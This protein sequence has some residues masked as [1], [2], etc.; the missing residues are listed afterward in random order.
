MLSYPNI[1]PVA[2]QLGPLAVHWY[3]LMY[4]VGF[5]AAW[6]LGRWR[7]RQS[8]RGWRPQELDDVV[9]Y[10][11]IGVIVGGR[12]GYVLFYD[13][14]RF[15]E[16]PAALLQV[17]RGGMSFHGGLLGVLVAL[18]LYGRR[19]GRGFFQVADFV[20][21]LIPPGLGAGRIGNFINGELWGRPSDLPWAMVFPD[22]GAGSLA[23]HPS[24]LYQFLLEGVALFAVLW[25]YSRRPRP[26]M[27]VSGLFLLVYGA[28]R[29]LVEFVRVPDEQ[30]GYLAFGWLT[31]GQ[32][33]SLPMLAFGGWLL[34][35]AGRAG[36]PLVGGESHVAPASAPAEVTAGKRRSRRR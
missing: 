35:R 36:A 21:P 3:G 20:A 22:P 14:A 23:R 27:A 4:L 24:Q 1:D 34:W 9:F 33:L 6:G 13:L 32:L 2:F 17:W 7:A 11:A 16:S 10:A 31:M 30:L 12:L 25:L 5:A 19:S 26:T 8:W 28:F 18:W 29:F 15:V